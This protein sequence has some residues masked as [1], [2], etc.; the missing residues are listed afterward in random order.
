MSTLLKN[1]D[2]DTTPGQVAYK[3]A[4]KEMAALFVISVIAEGYREETKYLKCIKKI[5]AQKGIVSISLV[6]VNKR[7]A[8]KEAAIGHSNPLKRLDALMEWKQN[9]QPIPGYD[10][11]DEYWLICDRDNHSFDNNQYDELLEKADAEGVKVVVSNPAF[12]IWLLLHLTPSLESYKLEQYPDSH[13]CIYNGVIPAIKTLY[14]HYSHGDIVMKVFE[15]LIAS[16]RKNTKTYEKTLEQLKDNIGTN[17]T[18]IFNRIDEIAA[19]DVFESEYYDMSAII[20]S[21]RRELADDNNHSAQ[22][23]K[24]VILNTL[25]KGMKTVDHVNIVFDLLC[26]M[27]VVKANT[28]VR[29]ETSPIYKVLQENNNVNT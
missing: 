22:E 9:C 8:S 26:H 14:P 18:S 21:L 17:I 15:P 20:S 24:T 11:K 12:Q 1:F 19:K 2:I 29:D 28:A 6:I 16:A 23:I 10:Q 27:T 25:D 4:T 3:S 13:D 5:C 7:Y